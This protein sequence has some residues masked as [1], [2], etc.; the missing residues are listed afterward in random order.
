MN[1]T[2]LLFV[3]GL[4]LVHIFAGKLRF[5][6]GIPRSIW[7]SIAGGISVAYVFIH[8]FPELEAAQKTISSNENLGLK[9]VE[10]HAYLLALA[11]LVFFY[12]L[13]RIVKQSQIEEGKTPGNGG[14]ETTTGMGIFWLHISSFAVFN[15][16][17]GYLIVHREE[18]DL[19]GL[20]F[21]FTAMAF[22]FLVNDFG[23]RRDHKDT[24]EKIG[25]WVLSAAVFIGWSIGLMLELS[26]AALALLFAFLAGGVILNILK[27][28]LPEE[29]QSYF[30][31]FAAGVIIYTFLLLI[32]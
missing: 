28:E 5:L 29:R 19:R 24:Y 13:E 1:V 31:A 25:R 21:F 30:W 18:N 8:I 7:L 16:L 23:L 17:I 4:A 6:E 14:G 15:F 22:Y 9:F 10:Y 12:G 20:I 3:I 2:T 27:E 32:T 11:G 26:D